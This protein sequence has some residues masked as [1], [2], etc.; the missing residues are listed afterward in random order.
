[1]L[2][3]AVG[4]VV[5]SGCCCS[6]ACA[7]PSGLI[8]ASM[9]TVMGFVM[10]RSTSA[11]PAWSGRRACG[12]AFVDGGH[13]V[14]RLV[15]L[16]SRPSRSRSATCR[17][18]RGAAARRPPRRGAGRPWRAARCRPKRGVTVR[19]RIGVQ[20]AV[21]VAVI[22]ALSIGLVATITLTA[23]ARADRPD[24]Q[25]RRSPERDGQDSTAT[26]CREPPRERCA[27]DRG[28]RRQE[29]IRAW[30]VQQ[31][32][33]R[34]LLRPARSAGPSTPG[35][36]STLPR[37]DR[38]LEKRRAGTGAHL[39]QRRR[40]GPRTSTDPE[41]D[42]LLAGACHAHDPTPVLGVLDV[43]MSLA[44]VDRQMAARDRVIL[45]PWRDRRHRAAAVWLS[46]R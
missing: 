18:S 38:P 45:A 10:N 29:R 15:A 26:T 8:A 5:R 33:D 14:A 37:Q 6:I 12:T 2:E 3:F 20:I 21:A 44:D 30:G 43:T 9:C 27:A 24:D 42:L 31:K 19:T 23:S 7:Q 46:R 4:V 32:A 36:S 35:R 13:R 34:L 40:A 17:S 41:R 25:Q 1:M 28:D 22:T 16:A 39:P 11:S